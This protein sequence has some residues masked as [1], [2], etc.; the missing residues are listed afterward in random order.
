MNRK[1]LPFVENIG[2]ATTACLFMM[3]QGNLMALTLTHWLIAS[4]TGI[5]AGVLASVAILLTRPSSRWIIAIVL[6]VLTT[7]V[8]FFVHPG[9]FGPVMLEAALPVWEP[10]FCRSGSLRSSRVSV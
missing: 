6:G 1:V 8:D 10:H 7:V 5:V 2:E 3:V 4:Q 9:E